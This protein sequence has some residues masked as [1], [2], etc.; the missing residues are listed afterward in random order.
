MYQNYESL[1]YTLNA[2]Q[3]ADALGISRAGAYQLLHTDGFPTLRVGKRMVVPKD[4]FV[5]WIDEN[6]GGVRDGMGI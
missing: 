4:R 5:R 2:E 1:P 6:I 3:I